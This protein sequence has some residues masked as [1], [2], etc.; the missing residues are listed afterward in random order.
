MKIAIITTDGRGT[1]VAPHLNEPV[2]GTAPEAL[3]QG[4]ESLPNVTVHVLSCAQHRLRSPDKLG[5]NIFFHSLYVPKLGWLRSGYQ[6]CI[7]AVRRKLAIIQPNIVHGQGSERECAITA[8]FSG[9]PNVVT[10]HGNM[11]ELARVFSPRPFTYLWLAARLETFTVRRTAGVFCNSLYTQSLV[12]SRARRV[13][14]VPNPI[15]QRFFE[16]A[17][18]RDRS[19]C[20]ITNIG[21]ISPRKRQVELLDLA[22]RLQ[23]RG[24]KFRLDFVGLCDNSTYGRQFLRGVEA[25]SDFVRH[26]GVLNTEEIIAQLDVSAALIHFPIEEAFGLVVCEALTRGLKLFASRTGGIPEI[27]SGVP[28]VELMDV[29]DWHGLE[30]AIARWIRDGF[31]RPHESLSLLRRR[32]HPSTIAQRHVEIYREVLKLDE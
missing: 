13:W 3:L 15:R 23:S 4:L 9:L 19:E 21:V 12:E 25:R 28:G 27:T 16:N 14:L 2:F 22:T 29:Q 11:A 31:P 8:V 10:I 30:V 32:Y 18:P 24:L 5:S 1:L 26:I 6:G 7:R 20:V 17:S